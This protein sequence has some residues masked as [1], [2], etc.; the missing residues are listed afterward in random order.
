MNAKTNKTMNQ[1]PTPSNLV[2]S[3]VLA[4]QSASTRRSYAQDV[5]HFKAN[6][7]IPATP[8]TVAEYLAKF[9]EVLSL[10]PCSTA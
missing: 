7:K 5:R 6:A 1:K 9:A 2:A 3:Y 10:P 4:A 8:E